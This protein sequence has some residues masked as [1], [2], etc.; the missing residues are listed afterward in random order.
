MIESQG[1]D[2]V[3]RLSLM[4]EAQL[5]PSELVGHTCIPGGTRSATFMANCFCL[6][7]AVERNLKQHWRSVPILD[8]TY[9]LA[10][11]RHTRLVVGSFT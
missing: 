7:P 9:L 6:P 2:P 10:P 4:G 1:I 8:Q 11:R 5:K 3:K